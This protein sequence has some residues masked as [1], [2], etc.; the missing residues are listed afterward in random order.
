[1][2]KLRFT[3]PTNDGWAHW[4]AKCEKEQRELNVAVL[5]G[6]ARQISK[7]LYS[8]QKEVYLGLYGQFYGKC[9]YCETLIA[10]N[11]PGDLDHFRPKGRITE[12]MLPVKVKDG[13]GNEVPHPGYYWLAYD[14]KNLLPACEDCNRPSKSK[15]AGRRIGKWDEFPVQDFRASSPGEEALER[16]LLL[17]PADENA[18][19]PA[20]LSFLDQTGVITSYTPEGDACCKIFG[21]NE[22][23]ALVQRRMEAFQAGGDAL[24]LALL[25]LL[26]TDIE[27]YNKYWRVV[28]KYIAG[29]MPYSAAG[30]AGILKMLER[31]SPLRRLLSEDGVFEL[32][33]DL[34][35]REGTPAAPTVPKTTP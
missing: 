9:A 19:I 23:E 11:H 26:H 27:G 3:K 30:R 4:R 2:I 21:L 15:T 5:S 24:R 31:L 25:S 8:G 16:P 22:R 18:D 7:K 13:S 1:M 34:C 35:S 14:A 17:N 10:E 29:E 12:S 20:H 6:Q 33:K 32:L 28:E